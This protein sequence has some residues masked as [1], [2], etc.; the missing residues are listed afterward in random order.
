MYE[1]FTLN[2]SLGFRRCVSV[3]TCVRGGVVPEPSCGPQLS[4]VFESFTLL[5]VIH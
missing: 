1:L 3:G 5:G 4:C 2:S